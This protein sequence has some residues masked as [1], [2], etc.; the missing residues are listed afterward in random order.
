MKKTLFVTTALAGLLVYATPALAACVNTG[1]SN[2]D[3]TGTSTALST[4]GNYNI[5]SGTLS[6]G[7]TFQGNANISSGATMQFEAVTFDYN[8]AITGAGTVR[9]SS[10]DIK[11]GGANN[12]WT[13]TLAL[14]DS[15]TMRMDNATTLG[16]ATITGNGIFKFVSSGVSFAN[17][18]E[19]T[20]TTEGLSFDTNGFDGVWTGD[21][22][23]TTNDMQLAKFGLGR[24][25]WT[26]VQTYDIP[27]GFI[28]DA[29]FVHQGILA[30]NGGQIVDAATIFSPDAQIELL[31]GTYNT[32]TQGLIP[33]GPGFPPDGG[34]LVN[35]HTAAIAGAQTFFGA[36]TLR[37]GA[38]LSG[39][40]NVA[41]NSIL[42][43]IDGTS[44]FVFSSSGIIRGDAALATGATI[45]VASGATGQIA[46]DTISGGQWNKDGAGTLA[47]G[48][49]HNTST[50]INLNAGGLRG[51]TNT[52]T[53]NIGM[54]SGTSIEF[55]Q[56]S[57]G[58]FAGTL[59]GSNTQLIK[60]GGGDLLITDG[61]SGWS[62]TTTINVGRLDLITDIT[63]DITV[64]D[65]GS[66]GGDSTIIG[67]VTVNNGGGLFA[68]YD[69]LAALTVDGDVV[70]DAGATLNARYIPG[71]N[72]ALVATGTVTIDDDA[73]L[74]LYGFAGS[75]APTQ[76]YS[77][78]TG[79]SITGT[80][81]TINN[82]LAF[83]DAEQTNTG[84]SLD[85]TLTRNT[86]DIAQVVNN[87]AAPALDNLGAGNAVYDAL[88]NLTTEQTQTA[89]TQ[90]SAGGAP[91]SL[92]S[93]TSQASSVVS[94]ISHGHMQNIQTA[95]SGNA[96]MMAMTD[97]GTYVAALLEP[98]VRNNWWLEATGNFG[99]N[100]SR[101]STPGNDTHSY[102]FVGGLD[103]P[104]DNG[105]LF[106]LYAS[107]QRGEIE[108]DA[109]N[110][111][112]D[113]NSYHIGAYAS[114]P[115]SNNWTISTGATLG[116]HDINTQRYVV[117]PGFDSA[118]K[119]DTS[120]QSAN[121]FIE[122]A[123][124]FELE[125]IALQPYA[126]LSLSHNRT[127][128][129]T[130]TNGAGA[131]LSIESDSK[132]NPS[133]TIGLRTGKSMGGL[134]L[135]GSL[136]WQHTYGDIGNTASM[137][138]AAGATSFDSSGLDTV[139]DAAV[140]GLGVN[141]GLAGGGNAYAGYTGTLSQE[142]QDHGF[143]A[144]LKWAF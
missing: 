25:E 37:N 120:G 114:R 1:G 70:L 18:F 92:G 67:N 24:L 75:Y 45:S 125:T 76:T 98:S 33:A 68:G 82:S 129:Y 111:S 73:T 26:G 32:N 113:I 138:F 115:L 141:T 80:F 105:D 8:G 58:T 130:E 103:L 86:L 23:T 15:T 30:M 77:F 56:A 91:A 41:R 60:S 13:G 135:S 136:G 35:G 16:T 142:G 95:S 93:F 57:N 5:I 123:K 22:H 99:S 79:H 137:R 63:S 21:M 12:G 108:T 133:T 89:V 84:T 44:T 14:Q 39:S 34:I 20:S 94:N 119:G 55:F 51:T 66:L 50:G 72:D 43:D 52:L 116:Y 2:Y 74:N 38:V 107:Y 46:G 121:V 106:G 3:C 71:F 97:P 61:V 83:L 10:A 127:K 53:G 117:F 122:A 96:N 109:V 124:S 100:E 28:A 140:V 54:A 102:G 88:M 134:N 90:L 132:T 128:G 40:G 101:G 64:N 7:S 29:V 69:A 31:G 47:M 6:A 78:I 48:A 118:P 104:Q 131:E 49:N 17:N 36:L 143:K 139:R 85:I 42:L 110:A 126:N 65:T 81:G 59:T 19:S 112:A 27:P 87:P 11:F 144:G 62:G 4:T 9:L